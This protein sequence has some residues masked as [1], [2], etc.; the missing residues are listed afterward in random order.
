[1]M[2]PA[3]FH[4][5]SNQEHEVER[6][7]RFHA[8][9]YDAT[10]WSFLFGRASLLDMIPVLPSEPQ[11]LE[12]GCGT[13]TTIERLEF[14][15]PDARIT[16]LDLSPDMLGKAGRRLRHSTQV[17]LKRGRYTSDSFDYNSF[18]L[19]LFSYSMTMFGPHIDA[20]FNHFL[21][22]L[23]PNGYIAVVDFNTSPFP[24][25]RR[26]MKFN[27]VQLDGHLLPL[28][29]KYFHPAAINIKKAYLGLWTYFQFVGK[30]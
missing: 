19:I 17:E 24:W 11:I 14:Y 20:F 5:V 21:E 4:T 13:G 9:L 27:H 28:L 3:S 12:V 30:P 23:K 18:D 16:G 10:R 7:Y 6:Y 25:F 22:D 2:D 8:P 26:W 15:F 1:M 29:K